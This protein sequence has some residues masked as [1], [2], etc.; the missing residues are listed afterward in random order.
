MLNKSTES[1]TNTFT[2]KSGFTIVELLIV[3]VVIGILAAITIVA[4]NGVQNRANDTT[5][6][7]DLSNARKKLELTKVDLGHYPRSLA[8][9]PSFK[10]T[11]SAYDTKL[12]NIY[13]ITDTVND[14]Y[15]LGVRSK[16]GK[17][18]ILTNTNLQEGV[19]VNGTATATAIGV[20]WGVPGTYAVLGL[21]TATIGWHATW[22]W[23]QVN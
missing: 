3:I 13:Y 5:V 18:F 15:A 20:T 2:T 8:E 12:N 19:A 21:D 4:F 9:F 6:S 23:V 14:L 22:P 11:R 10:I 17:G 1:S 7:T 16:T